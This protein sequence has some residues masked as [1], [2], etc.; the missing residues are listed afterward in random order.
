MNPK[1]KPPAP[2]LDNL[3]FIG[4]PFKQPCFSTKPFLAEKVF[5]AD[6]DFEYSLKFLYSYNGSIATY[7]SYRREIERLLQWSWRIEQVS[8]L[9]LKREHIEDF[10]RF[11]FNPP[12]AWIGVK[13]VARFKRKND[14][15]IANEDWRPFVASVSKSEH[16][17]GKEANTSKFCPSQAS[18]KGTF[19]ALGVRRASR[20]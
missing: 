14:K 19:T 15:R 12:K 6:I 10:I 3:T 2:I 7:N 9:N 8:V 5:G 4:N 16:D 17:K 20:T 11:C 18:I 13:N 1:R